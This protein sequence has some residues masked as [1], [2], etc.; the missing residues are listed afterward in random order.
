M[1]DDGSVNL[2][3]PRLRLVDVVVRRPDGEP[4]E[5]V[6]LELASG[7]VL[8]LVGDEASAFLCVS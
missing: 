4:S 2:P 1:T 3:S 5:P 6:D 8:I 7:G